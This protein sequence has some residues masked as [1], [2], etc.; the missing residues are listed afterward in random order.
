ME[1]K[2]MKIAGATGGTLD[3]SNLGFNPAF[4]NLSDAQVNCSNTGG[5]TFTVSVRP[6]GSPAFVVVTTA[7]QN[8]IVQIQGILFD[9]LKVT[10]PVGGGANASTTAFV[11]FLSRGI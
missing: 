9:S 10:Y 2:T 11:T 1:H 3:S 6:I 8:D 4:S 5:S 7:N